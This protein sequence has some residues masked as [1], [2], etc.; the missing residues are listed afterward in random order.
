MISFKE[1]LTEEREFEQMLNEKLLIVGGGKKQGQIIFMAGGAGSGKGFAVSNFLEG[2][3]FKVRDVDAWKEGLIELEGLNKVKN[4]KVIDIL[5]DEANVSRISELDLKNPKHVSVLHAVVTEMGIKKKTLNL[6]LADLKTDRLPNILFDI[7]LKKSGDITKIVPR[8]V[9]LGYDPKN[10]HL[11]W[12]LADYSVA[13]TRNKTRARVVPDD[14]VLKTHAGAA[15]T[16]TNIITGKDTKIVNSRTLWGDI[17]VIL[18][19]KENTIFFT[20]QDNKETIKNQKQERGDSL[21]VVKHFTS[22]QIKK[23]GKSLMTGKDI[24]NQLFQWIKANIP[25]SKDTRDIF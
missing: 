6:L 11:V 1:H 22:L 5:K 10:I 25:K 9:E 2:E 4:D 17:H 12:V 20:N 18:N 19:N 21:G 3:K 7:T 8:L 24:Q 14:V 23:A 16:M 13:V 15:K